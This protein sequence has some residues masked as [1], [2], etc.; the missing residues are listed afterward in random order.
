MEARKVTGVDSLSGL[1]R[2]Q[3]IPSD[4]IYETIIGPIRNICEEILFLFGKDS[5]PDPE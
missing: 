2:E 3:V 5:S 1:P 4:L